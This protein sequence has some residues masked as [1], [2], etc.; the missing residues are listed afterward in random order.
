MRGILELLISFI[1]FTFN[2]CANKTG[3]EIKQSALNALHLQKTLKSPANVFADTSSEVRGK[4][5]CLQ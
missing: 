2:V 1:L 5:N 3:L 4:L